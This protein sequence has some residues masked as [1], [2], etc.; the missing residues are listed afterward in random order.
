[1]CEVQ[2]RG[3]W[4]GLIQDKVEGHSWRQ[5]T[6]LCSNHPALPCLYISCLILL[7]L[8]SFQRK[9]ELVYLAKETTKQYIGNNILL[10]SAQHIN[11]TQGRMQG[12]GTGEG[13]RTR[14]PRKKRGGGPALGPMLKSLHRGPK[15]GSRTPPPPPW[16][17]Y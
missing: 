17:R 10:S 9:G 5:S 4:L 12:V 7:H 2:Y 8:S 16:I 6:D 14:S 13:Q 11:G 3:R 1:M 15:G